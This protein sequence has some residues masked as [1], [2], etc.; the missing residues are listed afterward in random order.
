MNV[1]THISVRE[2][3]HRHSTLSSDSDFDNFVT[4]TDMTSVPS[5][6]NPGSEYHKEYKANF[7]I[8]RGVNVYKRT[9]TTHF[10]SLLQEIIFCHNIFS[11]YIG[12]ILS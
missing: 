2:E 11:H 12:H 3:G 7:V 1:V 8:P 9:V 10:Y 6:P 5:N 4:H